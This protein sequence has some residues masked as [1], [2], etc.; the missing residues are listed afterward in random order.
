MPPPLTL[1]LA[2]MLEDAWSALLATGS[3]TVGA[4][5]LVVGGQVTGAVTRAV[6]VVAGLWPVVQVAVVVV[7]VVRSVAG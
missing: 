7:I 3:R 6:S 1:P 2:V 4:S 5:A